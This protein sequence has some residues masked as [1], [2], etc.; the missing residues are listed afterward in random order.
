MT[1]ATNDD[2]GSHDSKWVSVVAHVMWRSPR[3][4]MATWRCLRVVVGGALYP[5]V[6]VESRVQRQ[7]PRAVCFN[8]FTAE[9]GREGPDT[10]GPLPEKRRSRSGKVE[11]VRS[12]TAHASP[13]VS[14]V[15]RSCADVRWADARVKRSQLGR[16]S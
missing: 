3:P 15:A 2:S 10:R 11:G 12:A 5:E 6:E 16:D 8:S 4:K 1:T 9:R 14:A 7:A 13:H